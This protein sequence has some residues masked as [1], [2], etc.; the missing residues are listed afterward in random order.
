M[1]KYV[2]DGLDTDTTSE[3]THRKCVSQAVDAVRCTFKLYRLDVL[4]EDVADAR[5]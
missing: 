5:T 1:P 2:P 3:Q 4:V